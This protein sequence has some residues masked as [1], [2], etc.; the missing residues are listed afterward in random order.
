MVVLA[1]ALLLSLC[2][3]EVAQSSQN[4]KKADMNKNRKFVY[5]LVAFLLLV[6]VP[7]ETIGKLFD[8]G[9]LSLLSR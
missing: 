9:I 4:M 7:M 6:P 2:W 8:I 1:N 3:R 5:G